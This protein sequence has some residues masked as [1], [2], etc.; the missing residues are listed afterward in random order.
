MAFPSNQ[1]PKIQA[2]VDVA[3]SGRAALAQQSLELTSISCNTAPDKQGRIGVISLIW[4]NDNKIWEI[5]LG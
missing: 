2:L 3:T 4:N 1:I 5:Q